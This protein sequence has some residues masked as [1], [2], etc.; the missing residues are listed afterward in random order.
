MPATRSSTA[1]VAEVFRSWQGEGLL[2]G[3]RQVFVRLAGCTVGCRYC[4]TAWAFDT[5][6]DVA[7]PGVPGERLPNPLMV[8][9]VLSLIDAAD[10]VPVSGPDAD[11]PTDAALP[12]PC[13]VALTGGE[14]LEQPEF[15]AALLDALAAL[16][17][18]R[19]ALLETAGLHAEA[20][21]DLAPRARWIACDIK[22][23][24]AAG[25]PDVLDRHE[26]VLATGALDREGVF[27]KLIVDGDTTTDELDRAGAMIAR[28]APGRPVFLQPVTPLGGSPA[29]PRER[30]DP[31]ADVLAAHGLDVRLVPQ[32]HKQLG[33]R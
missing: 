3:R 15:A 25:L 31:C 6:A 27:F 26:V 21:V 1:V 22:L 28:H 14:P 32:V 33:V 18:P 13:P 12:E 16:P 10:P 20:L 11:A 23:P 17:V 8:D 29:L 24:S 7:V 9:H 2:L 5:P 30:F 19:D 4:D